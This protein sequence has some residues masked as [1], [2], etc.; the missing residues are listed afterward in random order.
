MLKP[1]KKGS[2]IGELLGGA[3]VQGSEVVGMKREAMPSGAVPILSHIKVSWS[4]TRKNHSKYPGVHVDYVG[5]RTHP[6]AHN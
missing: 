2:K 6:P 5:P 3:N 4:P 1:L